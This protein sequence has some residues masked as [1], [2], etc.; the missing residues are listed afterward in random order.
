MIAAYAAPMEQTGSPAT[1]R[2]TTA[3]APARPLPPPP[4][5]PVATRR[6]RSQ[7]SF[8]EPGQLTVGWRITT[9]I[10]WGLVFVGYIAVWKTSRELGLN[11]W[12]LGPIGDPAGWWVSM[13]PFLPPLAM[14]LLAVN[15]AKGLPWFGLG[16]A[17]WCA[18][19]ALFDLGLVFRLALVELAIAAAGAL[20][21][22]GS[23][24]GRLRERS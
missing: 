18:V 10:V 8:D 7:A 17:A 2:D 1:A 11:T 9:A 14:I 12:W 20:A 6:E 19:V 24:S 13:L 5:P 15:N 22:I 3:E 23:I 4:P 21:A 16:A